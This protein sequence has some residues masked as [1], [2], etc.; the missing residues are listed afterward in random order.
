MS[1]QARCAAESARATVASIGFAELPNDFGN[2]RIAGYKSLVSTDEFVA[3]WTGDLRPDVDTLV[4]IH[5][6]C[7]TSEVF[8]SLR[9]D[10]ANQ[11]K[12]TMDL[13]AREGLGVIVYQFQEGRGIG[14]LNKIRA[15]AL[16][17]GGADTV[18]ANQRLGFPPDL[19]T[20]QQCAEIL[21]DLNLRR[22]RMVSNNP[23][24]IAAVRDAGL[25]IVE[26]VRLPIE[27]STVAAQYLRTKQ[28]KLGHLLDTELRIRPSDVLAGLVRKRR[29][30]VSLSQEAVDRNTLRLLLESARWAPSSFNEQPWRFIVALRGEH[31][32]AY[33]KMISCL[34]Q[35]NRL[36]ADGA[37]VLMMTVA[38]SNFERNGNANRHAL[39]DDVGL[40]MANFALHAAALG[41]QV[42]QIGG[43]DLQA[44]RAAFQ[45]PVEYVPVTISAIGHPNKPED[46]KAERSCYLL[47]TLV[48]WGEWQQSCRC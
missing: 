25:E 27:I 33:N 46:E 42:H 40:A 6:Q 41:F 16:Q 18:E 10:C 9:C 30:G 38:K 12:A 48:Y 31:A 22:V 20:F 36:W 1:A 3:L 37:P 21:S 29:S 34:S 13:I 47:D 7:L 26:R 11:L 14:I 15:Y 24:K 45:I 35:H 19:R 17:D 5:S 44:A 2:F 8:G 28:E 32:A 43:F 23:H 4:R 39:H